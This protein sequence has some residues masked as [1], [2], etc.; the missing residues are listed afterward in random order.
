VQNIMVKGKETLTKI[1]VLDETGQAKMTLRRDIK[2]FSRQ[3]CF[4]VKNL[5]LPSNIKKSSVMWYP[6]RNSKNA[7]CWPMGN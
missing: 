3:S 7:L 2:E 4:N 5:P 6:E 1:V